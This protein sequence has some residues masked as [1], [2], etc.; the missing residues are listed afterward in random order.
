MVNAWKSICE[1]IKLISY[2]IEKASQISIKGVLISALCPVMQMIHDYSYVIFPSLIITE[3]TVGHS[4]KRMI[5]YAV[6]MLITISVTHIIIGKLAI[7][8][9]I[10]NAYLCTGF[11]DELNKKITRIDYEEL[12]NP[13]FLDLRNDVMSSINDRDLIN[14][15]IRNIQEGG[16]QLIRLLSFGSV[17]AILNPFL[18]LIMLLLVIMSI[19]ITQKAKNI[20]LNIEKVM[21]AYSRRVGYLESLTTDFKIGKDARIYDIKSMLAE[22]INRFNQKS[23]KENQQ[24]LRET[25]LLGGVL[26]AS[27]QLQ[28]LIIYLYIAYRVFTKTIGVGEFTLYTGSAIQLSRSAFALVNSIIEFRYMQ[29]Y[30]NQLY[31]LLNYKEETNHGRALID[32]QGNEKITIQFHNVSFTYPRSNYPALK[33]INVTIRNN[34][35]ISIV[36]ENGSGKTTFIKLLCGLYMPTEGKITLNGIDISTISPESYRMLLSVVFQD[37]SIFAASVGENVSLDEESSR[38]DILHALEQV[39]LLEKVEQLPQQLDTPIYKIF[40]KEGIDFSGGENQ[41]LAISRALY[42]NAPIMILDEP[43][44]SLDAL[45][46]QEIFGLVNNATQDKTTITISHRLSSCKSSDRILVFSNG[47]IVQD[48]PHSTLINDKRDK[49]YEMYSAQAHYYQ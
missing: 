6:L 16:M 3:M 9:K 15:L 23:H 8:S 40:D 47:E 12:E 19:F 28:M 10:Y 41:K 32:I 11:L 20:N 14:R 22:E 37:F 2:F 34:E 42:K 45:A 30:I 21:N 13:K 36:G 33:N 31:I 7:N 46:E 48:G 39:G 29:H 18:I 49:Y 26:T 44:A 43:T 1:T 4:I 38:G 25:V 5:I 27:E 17:L 24:S 35:H